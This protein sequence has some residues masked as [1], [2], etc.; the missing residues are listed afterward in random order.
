MLLTCTPA[1]EG[2]PGV[3]VG[4]ALH[5]VCIRDLPLSLRA[6]TPC[7]A[8]A[9]PG[10]PI[11]AHAADDDVEYLGIDI[12]PE[13][14]SEA[15]RRFRHLLNVRFMQADL[16]VLTAL[17]FSRVP[18]PRQPSTTL[19]FSRQMFQHQCNHDVRDL[20]PAC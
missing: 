6:S 20:S 12:V 9:V 8:L 3:F 15:S 2:A 18:Y 7:V 10:C 4:C 13:L 5:A 11:P 16:A 14:V 19:I 17:V 1:V